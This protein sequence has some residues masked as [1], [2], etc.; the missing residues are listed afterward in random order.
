MKIDVEAHEPAAIRGMEK[1]IKRL[2]P[3][4][5]TEFH[6]WAMQLNNID[7]PVAYLKQIYAL[8]YEFSIIE[9]SGRLLDV[10]CAEEILSY[11]SSLCQETVHLDLSAQP[12]RLS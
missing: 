8:G 5:I 10:S 3:K 1:L 11:W 4:I 2:K 12:V 7:P 6:P 9:P